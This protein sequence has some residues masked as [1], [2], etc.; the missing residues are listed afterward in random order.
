MNRYR[1]YEILKIR[2]K[3]VRSE[4]GLEGP[5]ILKS[6]IRRIYKENGIKLDYWDHPLKSLRGAYFND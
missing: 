3:E 1:Y 6:D 2:A 5:R 4:Y